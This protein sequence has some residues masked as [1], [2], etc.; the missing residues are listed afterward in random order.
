MDWSAVASTRLGRAADN[1]ASVSTSPGAATVWAA[2]SSNS[3]T[4]AS[5]NPLILRN[6]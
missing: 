6:G 1:L 4:S 5:S 2:G 3:G